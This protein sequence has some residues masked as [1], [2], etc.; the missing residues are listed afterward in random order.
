MMTILMKR[1]EEQSGIGCVVFI[2]AFNII[3]YEYSHESVLK[4]I[5]YT[6]CFIILNHFRTQTPLGKAKT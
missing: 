2:K 6:G 4:T 5:H 1:T 3:L